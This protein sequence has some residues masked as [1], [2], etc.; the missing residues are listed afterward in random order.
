V[1]AIPRHVRGDGAAGLAVAPLHPRARRLTSWLVT[2]SLNA[3][4]SLLD[5]IG[6]TPSG[7]FLEA[8]H[9]DDKQLQVGGRAADVEWVDRKTNGEALIQA[10]GSSVFDASDHF[11]WVAC[12]D[13]TTR[14][15]AKALREDY[16]IP[17]NPSRRRR[18]GWPDAVDPSVTT[19]LRTH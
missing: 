3:I 17:R 10:I 16:G 14:A 7:V 1:D 18:I 8:S 15:V 9:E 2:T 5:A 6:D 19:F 4:N 12:D 11:G 13:R